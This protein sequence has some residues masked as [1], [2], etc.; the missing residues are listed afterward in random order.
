MPK[1]KLQPTR[2]V[3][4]YYFPEIRKI[5]SDVT[6][7]YPHEVFLRSIDPGLDDFHEKTI[8]KYI[9]YN[10]NQLIGLEGFKYRYTASGSSESIF[11]I[12]AHILSLRKEAPLY[13][14]EG[15]YEGYAGYG[16][17]LGLTFSS[18]SYDANFRN[19]K[20]GIFFISN[21][22]ARDGNIIPDRK[23]KEIG[24]ADHEIIIDTAY[25]GLTKPH[26]FLLDHPS[27]STVLVSLSKEYGLYYYRIGFC[28]MRQELKTLM[29]NKWFK[30][31]LNHIIAEK[32]FDTL[33]NDELVNKY[34]HWQKKAIL[35]ISE[36]FGLPIQPSDVFILAHV[37][38]DELSDQK[39]AQLEKFRRGPFYRFCLTPYFLHFEK[40]DSKK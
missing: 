2:T 26:R 21:P 15:E 17:N 27:I 3:Y 14:L 36:E 6:K 24:N 37:N 30:N 9:K 22:S 25:V 35:M 20:K 19:L 23:I 32:I 31:I 18:V 28:F 10:K 8:L 29:V 7:N 1:S 12:L 13:V 4:S 33:K 38:S 5:I 34:L 11:H 40:E 39:K 16:G